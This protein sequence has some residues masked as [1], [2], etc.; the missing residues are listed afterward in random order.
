MLQ[1]F[2]TQ[3]PPFAETIFS[4]PHTKNHLQL[5][6]ESVII[7]SNAPDPCGFQHMNISSYSHGLSFPLSVWPLWRFSNLR[8]RWSLG[9]CGLLVF[10]FSDF[11]HPNPL[12]LL[13]SF[14]LWLD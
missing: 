9:M 14:S 8:W 1:A 12:L 4:I 5:T 6:A 3:L 10:S 13:P 2:K 11:P 7:T